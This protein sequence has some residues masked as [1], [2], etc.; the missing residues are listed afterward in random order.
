[1]TTYKSLSEEEIIEK[2]ALTSNNPTAKFI[3]VLKFAPKL[4]DNPYE[5]ITWFYDW[6]LEHSNDNNYNIFKQWSLVN[7]YIL[8]NWT[9]TNL[10]NKIFEE[11]DFHI[12]LSKLRRI[13]LK[14]RYKKNNNDPYSGQVRFHDGHAIS[15]SVAHFITI[16]GLY[17]I[18]TK[19]YGCISLTIP[20][21]RDD[22]K[23]SMLKS[24]YYHLK[25]INE[26][27]HNITCCDQMTLSQLNVLI[28][29]ISNTKDEIVVD[30]YILDLFHII[31][32]DIAKFVNISNKV[33]VM[34]NSEL[35]TETKTYSYHL[36]DKYICI[37]ET[38]SLDIWLIMETFAFVDFKQYPS[39]FS[40]FPEQLTEKLSKYSHDIVGNGIFR[41]FFQDA[42]M[43]CKLT[44]MDKL[45][46]VN[47][48]ISHCQ[49]LHETGADNI[50]SRIRPNA[51][52]PIIEIKEQM[53]SRWLKFLSKKESDIKEEEEKDKQQIDEFE[54]FTLMRRRAESLFFHLV[55]FSM[56]RIGIGGYGPT[57]CTLLDSQ[58]TCHRLLKWEEIPTKEH[59]DSSS[60]TTTTHWLGK[61]MG[62]YILTDF[63][64]GNIVVLS[65][66]ACSIISEALYYMWY[67]HEKP[68]IL[69]SFLATIIDFFVQEKEKY[70]SK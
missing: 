23:C 53:N 70:E 13:Y 66:D 40:E 48:D 56:Q 67:D 38:F 63:E 16:C 59:T 54:M 6:T 25:S 17:Y 69:S 34:D 52:G 4:K 8:N 49:I 32:C 42:L 1:M 43:E 19:K 46:F 15:S 44:E 37:L 18:L 51:L 28:R 57:L 39:Y 9:S 22:E 41:S 10:I 31:S 3:S 60:R 36:S 29:N 35:T 2:E 14:N 58:T 27:I 26:H 5:H 21:D 33:S 11:C 12:I 7:E 65:N 55:W 68:I 30:E 62:S 61:I 20:H 45:A 24:S 64:T 50:L 47:I